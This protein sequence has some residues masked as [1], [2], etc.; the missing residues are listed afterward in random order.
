MSFRLEYNLLSSHPSSSLQVLA[1]YGHH[2][3]SIYL[4]PFVG[5]LPLFQ[6]R[7]L[8]HSRLDS[9]DGGSAHRKAAACTQD[10]TTRRINAH[11]YLCLSGIRIHD[12]SVR[13]G[14]DCRC[15]RPRG[16]C[17]RR[18]VSST[19]PPGTTAPVGLGLPP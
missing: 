15:L 8:L 18:Q 7:H 19:P 12:P 16:Q 14:E 9:L 1:V 3:V 17:Y 6:F 10:S 13:V 5:P 2:Q 11:G 4:Q